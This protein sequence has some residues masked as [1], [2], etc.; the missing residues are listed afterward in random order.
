MKNKI[1][2]ILIIFMVILAIVTYILY[3]YRINLQEL[4]KINNE[5]KTYANTQMLGTELISIMNRVQD[6]NTKNKIEKDS[7]GLYR[8]NGKNSIKL[9][10]KLKYKEDYTTLEVEKILDN[11]IE[12]FIKTYSTASFKCIEITYHEKTGNVKSLTYIETDD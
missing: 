12:N 3:N 6:I 4:Q 9:Y 7:D 8:D 5:F 2:L 10:L 11:G 1:L